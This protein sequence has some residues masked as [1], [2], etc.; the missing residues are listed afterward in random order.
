MKCLVCEEVYYQKNE[1]IYGDKVS[2][3]PNSDIEQKGD[4]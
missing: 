4:I 3:I 1:T 2:T